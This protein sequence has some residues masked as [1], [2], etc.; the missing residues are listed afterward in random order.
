MSWNS[1]KYSIL[2][3]VYFS[4]VMLLVK[5]S[6][7]QVN[8][9]VVLF[10]L[11]P[12]GVPLYASF[13]RS[14]SRRKYF[15]KVAGFVVFFC[16]CYCLITTQNVHKI[17]RGFS[18]LL[19]YVTHI[20]III[21]FLRKKELI[22]VRCTILTLLIM[23]V[24]VVFIPFYAIAGSLK[25]GA[26][27]NLVGPNLITQTTIEGPLIASLLFLLSAFNVVINKKYTLL[28]FFSIFFS[29]FLLLLCN[30]RGL[31]FSSAISI[32]IYYFYIKTNSKVLLYSSLLLLF[33]P[34]FW[35]MISTVL[36]DLSSNP[37]FSAIIVRNN[38]SDLRTAT[39]RAICWL[40][41]LGLFFTYSSAY[42]FGFK[43]GPPE[44]VFLT[45]TENGRYENAHNTFLNLFLE[46]GYFIDLMFVL[47]LVYIFY[48]YA[49]LKKF[50][51]NFYMLVLIFLISLSATEAL[52][53]QIQ[54]ASFIFIYV[55]IGC[56]VSNDRT[57]LL[58]KIEFSNNEKIGIKSTITS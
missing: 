57:E 9:L 17:Y 13:L 6:N 2:L 42:I 31:I 33:L 53:R 5:I 37:L 40:N 7:D 30:R 49:K 58:S 55:L 29:V 51:K 36:F 50:N 35:D 15:F 16:I 39:G 12:L 46:A 21:W 4:Y 14:K 20:L 44:D 26:F 34:M 24:F 22:D 11:F 41:I 32:A 28:N 10:G 1:I 52:I 23:S 45:T 18:W 27:Y 3:A 48:R 54:L 43:G 19:I 25:F 8:E 38:S 47:L 56:N